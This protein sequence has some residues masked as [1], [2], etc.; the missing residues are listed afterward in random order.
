MK[1]GIVKQVVGMHGSLDIITHLVNKILPSYCTI[2]HTHTS[3]NTKNS[4]FKMMATLY[5]LRNTRQYEVLMM[6]SLQ[7][8]Q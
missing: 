4:V 2:H 8:Q 3:T 1:L 6:D 7:I 5:K